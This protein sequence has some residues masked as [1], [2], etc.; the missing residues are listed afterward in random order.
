MPIVLVAPV[1]LLILVRAAAT[2]VL[3]VALVLVLVPVA[4][5]AIITVIA[6]TI[7]L[8]VVPPAAAATVVPLAG[9]APVAAFLPVETLLLARRLRGD[10][11]SRFDSDRRS[12]GGG[13]DAALAELFPLLP[14]VGFEELDADADAAA[15]PLEERSDLSRAE[16]VVGAVVVI[17]VKEEDTFLD[18]LE[19]RLLLLLSLLESDPELDDDEEDVY[20]V[21]F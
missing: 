6:A 3:G 14:C 19:R 7:L 12:V 13:G 18:F 20:N 15:V 17:A 5:T 21:F 16:L 11:L 9:S 4:A 2:G 8:L 1:T 10:S